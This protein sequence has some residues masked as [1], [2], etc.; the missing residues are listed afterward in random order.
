MKYKSVKETFTLASKSVVK[1]YFKDSA[2]DGCEC[3]YRD[4]HTN[5]NIHVIDLTNLLQADTNS[6]TKNSFFKQENK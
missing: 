3:L 2:W 5:A 4:V 6:F 1:T